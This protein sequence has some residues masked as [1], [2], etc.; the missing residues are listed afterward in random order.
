MAQARGRKRTTNLP[1]ERLT[2]EFSADS[3]SFAV[4]SVE[5][6]NSGQRDSMAWSRS[7]RREVLRKALL[8][9]VAAIFSL[10]GLLPLEAQ[11][12]LQLGSSA[13]LPGSSHSEQETLLLDSLRREEWNK[14]AKLGE[15]L[16]REHPDNPMYC[17][18]LGVAR[19]SRHDP[20]GAIQAMR[21]AELLGLNTID[22]HL[23][24]GLEYYTINQFFL[25]QQQM[26]K[27]IEMDRN[28]FKPH[29]YMGRYRESVL[30]DFSGALKFFDKA[31]QLNPKDVKSW[32]HRGYCLKELGRQTDAQNAFE[33]AIKLEEGRGE[34]FSL[35]YQGMAQSLLETDPNQA[36][37]FARKAI[38]LEPN[39]E[40][41]HLAMAKVYERLG[42]LSE[43]EAELQ[44][45][46]QLDPSDAS[47]RFVSFRVYTRLGKHQAA[48]AELEAFKKVN[49]LYGAP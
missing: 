18:W 3:I 39:L 16:V 24:L 33:T 32:A 13:T 46:I 11:G 19:V 14:A 44:T 8:F 22:L 40:S 9:L 26:E 41:N 10:F 48:Q 25:F 17:Y 12:H 45:A 38:E 37:E 23:D 35:P 15:E 5:S 6:T 42:K 20:V 29:Y 36:L 47:A 4:V 31:V 34:R 1:P 27:A 2:M 7:I 28:S 21:S 43:A 49:Q 30:D